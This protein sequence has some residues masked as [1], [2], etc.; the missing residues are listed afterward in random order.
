MWLTIGKRKRGRPLVNQGFVLGVHF[1]GSK[2]F[3][4]C[5]LGYLAGSFSTSG[6]VR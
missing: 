5:L 2:Y 6:K 3:V 4:R 1:E